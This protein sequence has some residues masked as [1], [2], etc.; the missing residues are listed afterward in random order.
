MDAE[1]TT[2]QRAN[3]VDESTQEDRK[4]YEVKSLFKNLSYI[5]I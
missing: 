4:G 1:K 5:Q 2:V 3:I